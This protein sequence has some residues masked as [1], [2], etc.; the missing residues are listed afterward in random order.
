MNT[1][2]ELLPG[3]FQDGHVTDKI[4]SMPP[5]HMISMFDEIEQVFLLSLFDFLIKCPRQ[6]RVFGKPI[7]K[8]PPLGYR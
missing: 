4:P 7:V 5:T 1:I 6:A 8:S 3:A 2:V